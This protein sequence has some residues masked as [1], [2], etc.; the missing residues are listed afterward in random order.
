MGF[1]IERQG[2]AAGASGL[3]IYQYL[4]IPWADS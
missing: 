3:I 1:G 2:P 4:G